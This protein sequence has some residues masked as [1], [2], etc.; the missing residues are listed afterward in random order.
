MPEVF[1]CGSREP[2]NMEISLEVPRNVY[3]SLNTVSCGCPLQRYTG[4]DNEMRK[5]ILKWKIFQL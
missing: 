2:E 5:I 4:R 3:I 1:K